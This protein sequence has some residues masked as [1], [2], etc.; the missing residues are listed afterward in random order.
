MSLCKV[1]M[2]IIIHDRIAI[3]FCHSQVDACASGSTLLT[4][5]YQK[6]LAENVKVSLRY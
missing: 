6:N 3:V 1:M 2:S 5:L 4:N